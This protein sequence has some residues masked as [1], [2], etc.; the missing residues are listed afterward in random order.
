MEGRFKGRRNAVQGRQSSHKRV[1]VVA[2]TAAQR[3]AGPQ[4]EGGGGVRESL[5]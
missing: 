5:G 4:Q 3:G 1:G 2:A